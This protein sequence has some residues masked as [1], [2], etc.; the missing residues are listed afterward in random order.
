MTRECH[1]RFCKGLEVKFLWSTYQ[2]I[3]AV[4]A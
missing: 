1:V 2:P 4:S 3:E